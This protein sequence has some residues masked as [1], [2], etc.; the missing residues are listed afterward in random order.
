[1]VSRLR[2]NGHGVDW[3]AL[4]EAGFC[5]ADEGWAEA[6]AAVAPQV[7]RY[8]IAGGWSHA[9]DPVPWPAAGSL[10]GDEVDELRKQAGFYWH[11]EIGDPDGTVGLEIYSG[12]QERWLLQLWFLASGYSILV[13]GLPD[14]LALL[15]LLL[16]LV[17]QG[18][19]VERLEE[20]LRQ[21][22][23]RR[24]KRR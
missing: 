16:P 11:G 3:A 15:G 6:P 10:S 2:N 4:W 1:M 14:L 13:E 17:R 23:A 5:P 24:P 21:Q 19:D 12:Q 18:L 8:S 20:E 22:V 9:P 7:W